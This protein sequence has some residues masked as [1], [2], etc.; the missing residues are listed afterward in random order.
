MTDHVY[1]G[2]SL[3]AEA[4]REALPGAILHPPVRHG[5][6]TACDAGPGDRVAVVDGQFF[7]SASVRHK[8]ICA[9]L[10]RGAEVYGAASMGAL[11]AAELGPFGMVGHG[12]V[13]RLYSS[14]L[15]DRDDE[16]ALVHADPDAGA[17]P[18]TV[19][20]VSVRVA[21]RRLRRR[22]AIGPADETRLLEA[23]RRLPFTERTWRRLLTTTSGVPGNALETLRQTT[24]A[25]ALSWDVKAQD[26]LAL[27]RRL[28]RNLPA[29]PT[30]RRPAPVT[31]HMER[32]RRAAYPDDTVLVSAAQLY[33]EDYPKLHHRVILRLITGSAAED[34]DELGHHAFGLARQRGL[35]PSPDGSHNPHPGLPPAWTHWLDPEERPRTG[36]TIH[37]DPAA[38]GG[39]V[40][41][42]A[43]VLVRSYRWRSGL[44]PIPALAEAIRPLPGTHRIRELA[45]AADTLNATLAERGRHLD[46]ISPQTL[47]R[48][49]LQR[50]KAPDLAPTLYDRGFLDLGDL[51]A[52]ATRFCPQLALTDPPAVRLQGS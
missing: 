8:E 30:R 15:I 45:A 46:R 32:W 47:T 16:V 17:R 44:A 36:T 51:A 34:L 7:Q 5:D 26:A 11:R 3:P 31:T 14:G 25:P 50:W 20:L 2:P 13:H 19:A 22:G 4:A 38:D 1:L 24:A 43:L 35:F 49:C 52:R 23:A 37:Q 28:A 39:L 12:V 33:A 9:L 21:L 42:V 41:A 40:R 29:T 18:Y 48:L 6:L 10:D 27:L